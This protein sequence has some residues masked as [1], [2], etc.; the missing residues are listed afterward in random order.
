MDLSQKIRSLLSENEFLQLQLVDLNNT[1]AKRQE[2]IDF[3]NNEGLS[4]A[5]L[6]AKIASNAVEIDVLQSML[7]AAATEANA[8]Q[9]KSE[10]LEVALLQQTKML[11]NVELIQNELETTKANL[12]VMT[13][14]LDASASFYKQVVALKAKLAEANSTIA[15]LKEENSALKDQQAEMQAL[16]QLF[17]QKTLK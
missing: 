6:E 11:H 8:A 3:I 17:Q 14:E 10:H 12:Q 2:E 13:D 5:A 4:A 7:T 15:V 9:V 1:I 16:L